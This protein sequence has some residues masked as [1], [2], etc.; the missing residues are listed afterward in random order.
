MF[1]LSFTPQMQ[2]K[3]YILVPE[4]SYQIQKESAQAARVI[5]QVIRT[6][7]GPRAMQKMVIT[8]MNSIEVTNDGNSIL[9]EIDVSHPSARCLIEL[10]RTQDEE[11]G[12]GTTSVVVLASEFLKEM[13]QVLGKGVHP[14]T[15]SKYLT[16]YLKVFQEVLEDLSCEVKEEEMISIIR[17]SINTKICSILKIPIEEIALKSIKLIKDQDGKDQDN[18]NLNNI[19]V[20]KILSLNKDKS[21]V[22]DGVILNKDIIHP[23]MRKLIKNPRIVI[24]D[25]PL[26]YK[27]N[28]SATSYEFKDKKGFTKALEMEEQQVKGMVDHILSVNP[29]IVICEKGIS[30]YA[31]SMLFQNQITA[32]RRLKKTDSVRLSKATGTFIVNRLEDL[33]EKHVGIKCGLFEYVKY[34]EEYYCKFSECESPKACSVILRGPS[35]DVLNELERNYFDAVKVARNI[36]MNPKLVP[37][38]GCVEMNILKKLSEIKNDD[39]NDKLILN[40]L[41]NA[42]KSIPLILLKNSGVYNPHKQLLVLEEEIK[43]NKF[44]GIDGVSG[45]IVDIRKIIL[46]PISIKRQCFD[47][48]IQSVIQLLRV[49]GIL[50][51]KK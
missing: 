41:K 47:S 23:Q 34:G 6:C 13:V 1:P 20:E 2:K 4:N 30:D 5:S 25:T 44:S 21:E 42:I 37:G 32:I 49:D 11:V 26:E 28:E 46:E 51:S 38:G 22:I 35:K 8:K 33:E 31:L 19:K 29:D 27:K 24:L 15:I 45:K 50:E 10:A 14:I 36:L 43:K 9:R 16:T 7:L 12:D 48:A 3:L 40:G 17:N 39:K 18:I